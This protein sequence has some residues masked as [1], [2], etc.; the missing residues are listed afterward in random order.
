MQY[1]IFQIPIF[2]DTIDLSK[3]DIPHHG[4]PPNESYKGLRATL[5]YKTMRKIP[6][7]TRK[8]KI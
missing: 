1:D 2:I 3:I 4:I 5:V 6:L 7:P 8:F